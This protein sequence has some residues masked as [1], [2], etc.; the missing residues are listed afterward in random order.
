VLL[1]EPLEKTECGL[2][3][4]VESEIAKFGMVGR[5]RP[6]DFTG[7]AEHRGY[8]VIPKR[9]DRAQ[10]LPAGT[11]YAHVAVHYLVYWGRF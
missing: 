6:R 1:D 11:G 2:T 3:G 4:A 7:D 8:R 5:F 10:M 9:H